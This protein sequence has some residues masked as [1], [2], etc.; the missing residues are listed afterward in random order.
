M[1]AHG[2]VHQGAEFTAQLGGDTVGSMES[3]G[4]EELLVQ[5][6]PDQRS[7]AT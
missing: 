2:V 7:G 5:L 3:L 6:S 1:L 4:H